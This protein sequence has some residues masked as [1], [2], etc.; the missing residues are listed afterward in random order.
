MSPPPPPAEPIL[1]L[2]SCVVRAY[3]EG[4]F[5]SL[6]KA[7]NNPK[8]ACRMR[9]AFP[10]PYTTD[11]AKAWISIANAASPQRDFAI[12][13]PGDSGAV[14]G[15]IG[16]KARDDVHYRT[17]EIGYWL[18]EDYWHRGIATEVVSA[19]SDWVF[20]EFDHL[21]RLEAEVFEGNLASGRV[22]EKAGFDFEGRQKKA[23]E[24]LGTVMDKLV[25]C[26][27]RE[28]I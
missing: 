7:A 12:C 25:Y 21:I 1:R 6:A 3:S 4:D 16:L 20:D 13:Q 10:Q 5:K 9:N 19:F 15:G 27:F 24:K 23:V 18:C 2:R 22:L 8:I 11:D 17:M 26:K 28:Q 14:I